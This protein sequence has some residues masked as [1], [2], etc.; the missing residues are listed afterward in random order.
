MGG[1]PASIAAA[2]SATTSVA[3]TV[4][5]TAIAGTCVRAV[6]AAEIIRAASEAAIR[7]AGAEIGSAPIGVWVLAGAE[8]GAVRG[9][10]KTAGNGQFGIQCKQHLQAGVGARAYC[11]G[12]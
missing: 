3:A 12:V 8:V 6:H 2:T 7:E 4:A 10:L 5:R 9:V 11:Q 1:V